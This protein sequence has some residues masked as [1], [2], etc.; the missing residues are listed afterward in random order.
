MTKTTQWG[1]A[2]LFRGLLAAGLLIA[3]CGGAAPTKRATSRRD[4]LWRSRPVRRCHAVSETVGPSFAKI[5]KGPHATPD[6]L[7]DFLRSTH[8]DVS[9]PSAMPSPEL[10]EQQIDDIAA[11]IASLR[12]AK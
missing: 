6:S 1:G 12:P 9:H 11:Y 5:A 10:T 7:R 4:M 8:S 3:A 2:S